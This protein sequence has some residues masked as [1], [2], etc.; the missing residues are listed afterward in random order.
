MKYIQSD[1]GYTLLLTLVL[2]VLLIMI[3]TTFTMASMNQAKQVVKTDDSIVATS[4][5]EMGAEYLEQFV[6]ETIVNHQNL[7]KKYVEKNPSKTEKQYKDELERLHKL[8]ISNIRSKLNGFKEEPF[9]EINSLYMISEIIYDDTKNLLS[10]SVL[11]QHQSTVK[12]LT[13][14]LK[15]PNN[16]QIS[17]EDKPVQDRPL[18]EYYLFDTPLNY[19][20]CTSN[21]MNFICEE[22]EDISFDGFTKTTN[23]KNGLL[24]FGN[25]SLGQIKINDIK[26]KYLYISETVSFDKNHSYLSNVFIQATNLH[27]DFTSASGKN[28]IDSILD[29]SLKIQKTIIYVKTFKI[30]PKKNNKYYVSLNNGSKICVSTVPDSQTIE[31]VN[32]ETPNQTGLLII[33]SGSANLSNRNTAI[34]KYMMENDFKANCNL[35]TDSNNTTILSTPQYIEAIN[36][37]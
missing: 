33:N 16:L 1:K 35:I 19:G 15:I 3:T 27:Y 30:T 17:M 10:Y 34:V 13:I 22:G 8:T 7:F 28:E 23:N 25:L 24:V 36:Y 37:E 12:E 6:G 29:P 4:L 5:A 26:D 32:T 20:E 21:F 2:V 18:E 9:N 14:D 11:G 31:L